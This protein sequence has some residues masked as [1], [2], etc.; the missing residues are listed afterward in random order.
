MGSM[1][2]FRDLELPETAEAVSALVL[3]REAEAH[4]HWVFGTDEAD[5]RS[6][7]GNGEA[8]NVHQFEPAVAAN[9]VTVTS[10][11]SLRTEYFKA[12]EFSLFLVGKRNEV[13]GGNMFCGNWS[14]QSTG[15]AGLF[16]AT[17]NDAT[18][19]LFFRFYDIDGGNAKTLTLT[20]TTFTGWVGIGMS[21][22]AD[23]VTLFCPQCTPSSAEHVQAVELS[24][25]FHDQFFIGGRSYHASGGINAYGDNTADLAEFILFDRALTLQ[26]M[27]AVHDRSVVRMA[28]RGITIG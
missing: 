2:I 12:N 15:D 9:Y 3:S 26:E 23:G 22:R 25:A 8:A 18:D 28:S 7:A 5:F 17:A 6:I 27:Q 16:V 24:D 20:S 1:I 14:V 4:R 21:I 13:S 10:G 19:R 11:T